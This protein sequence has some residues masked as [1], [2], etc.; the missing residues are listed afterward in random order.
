MKNNQ[1]KYSLLL[2]F[3]AMIWGAAFV[4]QSA[5]MEHVGPMTFI[6]VRFILGGLVLIP[7]IALFD[8]NKTDR[9]AWSD[10]RLLKGGII[11]GIFLFLASSSQQIGM[12]YTSAGKAGFITTFYIVMV[13]IFSIFLKKKPGKLIVVSIL[14]AIVGLYFLCME[15]GESFALQVGDIWLFACAILFALQ[16]LAVD[17]FA[18]DVDCL[19]LAS[20]QFITVGILAI[21]PMVLEKPE[22][23]NIMKAWIS[24]GYAGFFSSGVAYTL[25]MVAQSKVKPALASLLMSFESVFSVIFGFIILKERL[26]L[27]QGIGC[28]VMFAAVMLAQFGPSANKEFVKEQ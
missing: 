4:A 23:G 10:K 9:M 19:K 7:F 21:I 26:T 3:T 13:P 15:P 27:W 16:I 20:I 25:Q 18:P 6:C 17:I 1:L 8:K 28:I 14:I 11:C 5:G 2:L 12:Q 24:I 22:F